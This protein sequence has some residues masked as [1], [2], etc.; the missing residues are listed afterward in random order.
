MLACQP[1]SSEGAKQFIDCN[2]HMWIARSPWSFFRQR[3]GL[4]W[5]DELERRKAELEEVFKTGSFYDFG[6]KKDGW[7]S[8]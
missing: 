3:T 4:D 8:L 6:E 2:G 5:A 1:T 7:N